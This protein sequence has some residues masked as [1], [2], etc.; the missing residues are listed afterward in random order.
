MEARLSWH[1]P[2]SFADR[3]SKTKIPSHGPLSLS[4]RLAWRRQG[5]YQGQSSQAILARLRSPPWSS[6]PPPDNRASE[7]AP[8]VYL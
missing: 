6:P 5:G 3:R 2:G 4:E 7:S 8:P 1:E